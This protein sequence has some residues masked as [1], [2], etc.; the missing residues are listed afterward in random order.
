MRSTASKAESFT[1][2]TRLL[3]SYMLHFDAA[4]GRIGGEDSGA[5]DMVPL[6]IGL[7]CPE[8]RLLFFERH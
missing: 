2:I 3:V 6:W 8:Q 4:H 1:G 5:V 7:G